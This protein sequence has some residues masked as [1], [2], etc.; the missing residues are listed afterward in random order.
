MHHL[1]SSPCDEFTISRL[2][3]IRC[4]ATTPTDSNCTSDWVQYRPMYVGYGANH[5]QSTAGTVTDCQ[6]ACDFDP[7]CVAVEWLSTE[8]ERACWINT[9]PNHSH[10]IHNEY[11]WNRNGTHYHL[12]SR[13]NITA[14]QCFQD[15]LTWYIISMTL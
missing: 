2:H 4:V 13:C 1:T 7:H 14:G 8:G 5:Q 12:V 15:I 11:T 6:N 3:D 9:L 10:W